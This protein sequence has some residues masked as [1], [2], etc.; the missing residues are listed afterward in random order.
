MTFY[1]SA[2]LTV[3]AI[4]VDVLKEKKL[5][6]LGLGFLCCKKL[7]RRLCF[8][9]DADI[10]FSHDIFPLISCCA[11]EKQIYLRRDSSGMRQ[12]SNPCI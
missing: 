1:S 3:I 6:P 10:S 11:V 8:R 7:P 9:Q 12:L 4:G 2:Q 5:N